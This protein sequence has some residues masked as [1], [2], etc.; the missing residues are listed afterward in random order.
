[1]VIWTQYRGSASA[2][3]EHVAALSGGFY[4][5][6][7]WAE[8]RR[9]AGWQALRMLAKQDGQLVC[10]A[11]I[12][13]K[14]KLGVAVCWIPGGPLGSAQLLDDHFR[15]ALSQALGTPAVYCRLSLLRPAQTG[16]ETFLRASSWTRPA[17]AMSSGLT[18]CYSLAGDESERLKRTSG[19]WR[20]NLK[21][22]GRYG[23]RIEHWAHP[24]LAAI[25]ALYREMEAL[26]GLPVQHSETEL[27]A[28]FAQCGKQIVI[29]RCLDSAGRLLALRAAGLCATTAMDLLAAAG[30]EAR[31][32]YASHATLWGLLDHCSQLGLVDYDLSGVDPEGNKGVFD[33]KHGTGAVLTQCL[34]EWEWAS[35]PGLC[36]AVNYLLKRKGV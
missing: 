12:L 8:V 19:N 32:V 15:S 24:D 28:M 14:R 35:L 5:S 26:K 21:R 4:Q 9:V 31:K 13:V 17:V 3:D 23:L 6:Y 25:S 29:Y 27:A 7:G 16:E 2:W 34:G 22:S 20:H 1:M 10:A 36:S 30:G 11:S 18:M 33:F